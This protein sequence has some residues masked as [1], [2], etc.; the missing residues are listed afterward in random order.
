MFSSDTIGTTKIDVAVNAPEA[1]TI[2]EYLA[3]EEDTVT[4]GQDLLKIE[5]GGAPKGEDK[6]DGG[7]EPK[8]PASDDQSTSTDPKPEKDEGTS[9]QDSSSTL[10]SSPAEQKKEIESSKEEERKRKQSGADREQPARDRFPSKSSEP[11]K[12]E[13]KKTNSKASISE[14]P[15]GNREE[16]RVWCPESIDVFTDAF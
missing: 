15:Y 6:Q 14:G 13:S 4:V 12:S 7:Q 16:R 9:G 3:N 5:L 1:G 10:M 8:A 11:D 2:K